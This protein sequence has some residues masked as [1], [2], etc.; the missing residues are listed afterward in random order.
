LLQARLQGIYDQEN[1]K[2]MEKDMIGLAIQWNKLGTDNLQ[3]DGTVH[4]IMSGGPRED[5]GSP[6]QGI[7][8]T[9][10]TRLQGLYSQ[11]NSANKEKNF[12]NLAMEWNDSSSQDKGSDLRPQNDAVYVTKDGSE[13][14][15][16]ADFQ[17]R[18]QGLYDHPEEPDKERN[19]MLLAKAWNKSDD[20]HEVAKPRLLN[21]NVYRIERYA[22]MV[23]DEVPRQS[24]TSN[25]HDGVQIMYEHVEQPEMEQ[26]Y[27]ELAE[28][29][30]SIVKW[31]PS[32]DELGEEEECDDSQILTVQSDT[33][34]VIVVDNRARASQFLTIRDEECGHTKW[35]DTHSVE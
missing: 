14:G 21:S 15:G 32:E 7:S 13:T 6:W 10:Q 25:L 3:K 19:F 31:N 27:T 2:F 17:T 12:M 4:T 18:L 8:D 23:E 29:W 28:E 34:P 35:L 1:T 26:A 33:I 20:M 22:T 11:D 9:F 5:G 30:N 24:E 16:D